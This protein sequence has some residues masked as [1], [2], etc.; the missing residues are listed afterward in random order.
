M[1]GEE[2]LNLLLNKSK[3]NVVVSKLEE[4]NESLP[5][6]IMEP[7]LTIIVADMNNLISGLA[8]ML[9]EELLTTSTGLKYIVV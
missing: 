9:P 4:I 1:T 2:S 5:E 3:F 6:Q 8:N 7:H